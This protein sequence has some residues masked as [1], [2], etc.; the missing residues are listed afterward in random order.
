MGDRRRIPCAW[1]FAVGLAL[2]FSSSVGAVEGPPIVSVH[3]TGDVIV[4]P[5]GVIT[6]LGLA[7]G[8]PVDRFL[9]RRGIHT[10]VASGEIN[11]VRVWSQPVV[12][13]VDV[14]VDIER[15]ARL[16]T[17]SIDCPS[18]LWRARIRRWLEMEIGNPVSAGDFETAVNRIRRQLVKRGHAK[19]EVEVVLDYDRDSNSVDATLVV[20]PGLLLRVDGLRIDGLPATV[21]PAE[22]EP[23]VNRGRRLKK[24]LIHKVQDEVEKTLRERNYW[25]ARVITVEPETGPEGVTLV[26]RIDP[27]HLYHLVIEAPT[28]SEDAVRKAFPDPAKEDVNPAQ[29]EVLAE[30][31]EDNLRAEGWLL[32]EVAVGVEPAGEYEFDVIVKARPGRPMRVERVDFPGISV[33][34]E[35]ELRQQVSV[36]RRSGSRRKPVTSEVLADDRKALEHFLR[37]QGFVDATVMQPRIIANG[38]DS[39]LVEFPIEEGIRWTVDGFWVEG[40]P[41]EV[42]AAIDDDRYQMEVTEPYDSRRV[43]GLQTLWERRMADAGYPE[44]RMTASVETL[45]PG[46]VQVTLWADPG[47]FVRFG[48][49]VLSGLQKTRRSIVDRLLRD[50]GLVSGAPYS[51]ATIVKAQQELYRLGIFRRVGVVP[52]PGHERRTDRDVVVVLEEG[53]QKS[54]LVGLGWGTEDKFRVSLGW[55][56]LNLFRGAHAFSIQTRYSSREFRYQ[57]SLHEPLLPLVRTPGFFALYQTQEKLSEFEQ[58]RRGLWFEIGDRLKPHFRRWVRYEYSVV[59]PDAPDDVLSELERDQQEIQLSAITP[60]FEWDYRNDMLNPKSGTLFTLA[61][62]YAFPA[63]GAEAEFFKFRGGVSHYMAVPHGTVAVG[64][65]L[66][67]TWPFSG[68]GSLPPNLEV[69]LAVRFFSGGSTTH[70]AFPTDGLGIVGETIS[71]D[72]V[73]IGGNALVLVNLEYQRT[74]WG[75][76]Q[77]VVFVDG[78]NVWADPTDVQWGEFRWGVGGGLR[79]DTPAGPFRVEYGHKLQRQEGESAGEFNFSFGVVF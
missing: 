25:E 4:D 38:E 56:N 53:L 26:V 29:S 78:G 55:S 50:A 68:D 77:A 11:R 10:L 7:E 58:K 5:Q 23:R 64:L 19:P 61:P 51:Q 15:L 41:S 30:R 72:G 60:T 34:E 71:P 2:V 14:V 66:G 20:Q 74:I 49:V 54:Y 17:M 63:F 8:Q 46:R 70:R 79:Y 76:F 75:A 39:V 69:P 6:V 35:K 12:D 33:L 59:Q 48:S 65:R 45:E 13:G 42:V 37:Q 1:C 44:A 9:V 3:L 31:I 52:V 28:G 67:G 24:S 62:Q 57:I 43:E 36:R 32:A 22:V 21:E 18:I 73:A 16:T 27:G 40:I 47:A